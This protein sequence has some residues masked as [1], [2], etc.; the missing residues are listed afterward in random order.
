MKNLLLVLAI[1]SAFAITSCGPSAE[2]K[3]AEQAKLDSL[4]QDSI[5]KVE[6]DAQRIQDSI[7]AA[8]ATDTT[9]VDTTAVA[10]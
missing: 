5:M 2:E 9:A 8:Q 6:A 7:T 4:K 10:Q 3:A 1:A